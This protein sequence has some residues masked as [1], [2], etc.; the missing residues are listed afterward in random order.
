MLVVKVIGLRLF[1]PFATLLFRSESSLVIK[2]VAYVA[3]KVVEGKMIFPNDIGLGTNKASMVEGDVG[4]HASNGLLVREINDTVSKLPAWQGEGLNIQVGLTAVK[5]WPFDRRKL[6]A[7]G[8][9]TAV[10]LLK[11]HLAHLGC[12]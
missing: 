12:T 4:E 2:L 9:T 3:G 10:I 8:C 7:V 1:F 11:A 6:T 5:P